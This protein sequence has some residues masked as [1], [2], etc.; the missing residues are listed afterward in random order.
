[1]KLKGK[2]LLALAFVVSVAMGVGAQVV[3]VSTSA[4]TTAV[5]GNSGRRSLIIQNNSS[6][7]DIYFSKTTSSAT[8]A[9]GNLLPNNNS[10]L[11]IENYTGPL[12]AIAESSAAGNVNMHYFEVAR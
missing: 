3:S 11:I 5:S 6:T 10:F 7:Q 12:Y 1:M 4:V 2:L 9:A 8:V